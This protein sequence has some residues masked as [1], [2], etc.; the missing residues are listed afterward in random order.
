MHAYCYHH[1]RK[2][3]ANAVMKVIDNHF[4]LE[5]SGDSIVIDSRLRVK[6]NMNDVIRSQDKLFSLTRNYPKGD[7]DSFHSRVEECVPGA[8][9]VPVPSLKGNRQDKLV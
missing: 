6:I 2:V 1:L 9:L 8:L 3:C 4:R 7:V 5:I